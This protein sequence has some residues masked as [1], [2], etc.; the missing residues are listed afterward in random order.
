MP[1]LNTIQFNW[2]KS[3][4]PHHPQPVPP[5]YEP[6]VGA[7][8][9]A[10]VAD[11]PRRR[12]WVG[13]PTAGTILGDRFAGRFMDWYLARSAFDGQQAPDKTEPMLPNNVYGPVPGDHGA[14][15]LFSDRAHTMTPQI[16]MIRHRALS[17]AGAAAAVAAGAV[18][19]VS[20]L[21]RK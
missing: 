21:R 4:L 1:A 19:V 17:Y 7:I 2:V 8:A 3:Q 16:W 5:I 6:E 15:G 14:R 20:A 11:K 9:I 10:D 13:E 18:G 12:T